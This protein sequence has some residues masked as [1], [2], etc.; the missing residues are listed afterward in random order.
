MAQ[1]KSDSGDSVRI[2]D[3]SADLRPREELEKLGASSMSTDRLLALILRTG[4]AGE[5]VVS[6]ASRLI[7]KA[8]GITALASMPHFEIARLGIPGIGKV[9]A[10][11]LAAL[12]ELGRRAEKLRSEF[13]KISSAEDVYRLLLPE[14]RG[15]KQEKFF[16]CLLDV[17]NKLIGRP[18]NVA[19]GGND[20]CPLRI[21]DVLAPAVKNQCANIIVAHN[22]PSGDPTPSRE[23]IRTTERL[24]DSAKLL[25]MR[26]LDHIVMGVEN[27][28]AGRPAFTSISREHLVSL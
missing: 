4:R 18:F 20:H 5:N 8:G 7:N 23:D 2:K 19:T 28:A 3:L 1:Q 6:L 11:E 13:T 12:F 10:M 14:V 15:L 21:T 25:G 22:H 27:E 24:A 17:K 26:L 16:V 9:K